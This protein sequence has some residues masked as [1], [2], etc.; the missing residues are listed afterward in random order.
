M[1][2]SKTLS[3]FIWM[4]WVLCY[5]HVPVINLEYCDMALR[6]TSKRN[7]NLED[8]LVKAN[9]SGFCSVLSKCMSRM[10]LNMKI[11]SHQG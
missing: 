2:N 7:H 9:H 1:C 11:H 6:C 4:I 5:K 10:G 3:K 8:T